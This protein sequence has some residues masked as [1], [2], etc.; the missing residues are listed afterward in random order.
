MVHSFH[1]HAT[2]EILDVSQ[3]ALP[4]D[5]PVHPLSRGEMPCQK[6]DGHEDQKD[7]K[8]YAF[9]VRLDTYYQQAFWLYQLLF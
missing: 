2:D 4:K 7:E 8:V 1:N 5:F 6:D 3:N 9:S